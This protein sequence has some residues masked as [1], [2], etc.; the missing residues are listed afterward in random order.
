MTSVTRTVRRSAGT[1]D[2][3]LSE[4]KQIRRDYAFQTRTD[5]ESLHKRPEDKFVSKYTHDQAH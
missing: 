2:T 5:A 3:I 4:I 1:A